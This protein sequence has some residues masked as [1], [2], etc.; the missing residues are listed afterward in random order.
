MRLTACAPT[1]FVVATCLP[2]DQRDQLPPVRIVLSL[3]IAMRMTLIFSIFLST[4]S[5]S[6]NLHKVDCKISDLASSFVKSFR[7]SRKLRI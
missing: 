1:I 3:P 2:E 6:E 5:F 4:V 7:E